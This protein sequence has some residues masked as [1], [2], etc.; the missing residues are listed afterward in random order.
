MAFGTLCP[1]QHRINAD[2]VMELIKELLK[3]IAEY[4]QL[5]QE[6]F[7]E[8]VRKAQT[9][10]QSSEITRLKS[11]LS[12][13]Q[14]RVQDLEKLFFYYIGK[15]FWII[16]WF[17]RDKSKSIIIAQKSKV[18]YMQYIQNNYNEKR[19]NIQYKQDVL[20]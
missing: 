1:T 6:E 14:K 20:M 12:E 17:Y 7:I 19:I 15:I 9:T 11:R 18:K 2:V 3:A 5:N 10:Q 4:S 8:M 13:A 16:R